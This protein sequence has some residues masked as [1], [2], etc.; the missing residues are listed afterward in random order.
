MEN[1][2]FVRF[3]EH[4]PEFYILIKQ[5]PTAFVL[6]AIIVDRARKVPVD[7][8]AETELGEAYIG[9][10]YIYGATPQ[11]YRTDKKHLERLKLIT[12]RTTNKGTIAK[13]V[14]SSIF[15]ISRNSITSKS[16]NQQ[17]TDNM[18][19]TTKQE[20]RNHIKESGASLAIEKNSFF[21]DMPL[22]SSLHTSD[23]RSR[24]S[25]HTP[26]SKEDYWDINAPRIAEEMGIKEDSW[27]FINAR[28]DWIRKATTPT[29]N[30]IRAFFGSS[31]DWEME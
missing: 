17:Q 25:I 4:S 11:S 30:S 29:E 23:K 16:T 8:N 15:D 12:C 6:L 13:I 7:M 10:Y 5:R 1:R 18:L 3:I 21:Q 28:T 2:Y 31:N 27:K 9:D 14:N 20:V 24:K 26:I 19:P 22:R